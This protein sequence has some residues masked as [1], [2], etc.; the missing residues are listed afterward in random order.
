[1]IKR[2]FDTRGYKL[3]AAF[4]SSCGALLKGYNL[5]ACSLFG[6][7]SHRRQDFNRQGGN[8]TPSLEQPEITASGIFTGLRRACA[9]S[10]MTNF[11]GLD[12]IIPL[13]LP[14][15]KF[16]YVGVQVKCRTRIGPENPA[17]VFDGM[18]DAWK[19]H[20]D[21]DVENP[22]NIYLQLGSPSQS[23]LNRNF[24][25]HA[26]KMV[27][28]FGSPSMALYS[29]VVTRQRIRHTIHFCMYFD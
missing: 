9:F 18:L 10:M 22:L 27:A 20:A 23:M 7:L 26:Y 2:N 3:I 14:D 28:A 24:D 13:S 29:R 21:P 8:T 16:G 25:T 5:P 19:A 17:A 1:M 6:P 12:F 11:P 15:G 4:N